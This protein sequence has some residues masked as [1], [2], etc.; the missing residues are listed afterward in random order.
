MKTKLWFN[1]RIAQ[2]IESLGENEDLDEVVANVEADLK[3][4]LNNLFEESTIE[5]YS[6]EVAINDQ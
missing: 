2:T 3:A 1:V 4:T 5:F 6:D